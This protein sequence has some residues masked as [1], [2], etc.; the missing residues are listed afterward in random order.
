MSMLGAALAYF[1]AGI[2]IIPIKLDGSKSPALN[3]WRQL[4]EQP[5]S[6][7][8][9]TH[10]FRDRDVGLAVLAGKTSGG[11]T[12]IDFD[13]TG[14]FE[15]WRDLLDGLAPGLLERLP[16]VQT[17]G[18]HHVYL[19]ATVC[20]RN[21]KLAMAAE[22]YRK[23]WEDKDKPAIHDVVIETRGQGGYVVAPP[24]PP[25]AH[26][27]GIAY[28]HMSGPALTEIP[29]ITESEYE[30]L[31]N[32]ARAF[33]EQAKPA[34]E[35]RQTTKPSKPGEGAKPGEDFDARASWHE[36]LE[37][38]GWEAIRT[39]GDKTYWR[40]PGKK[41]G[42]ISA[43]TGH[44]GTKL[45]VFSSSAAPFEAERA[46]NKFSAY[47][48]LNCG[49]DYATAAREL[50]AKGFGEQRQPTRRHVPSEPTP[51]KWSELN[52]G[53]ERINGEPPQDFAPPPIG[54]DDV[55]MEY[56]EDKA[57]PERITSIVLEAMLDDDPAAVMRDGVFERVL[58][59][60]E[61]RAEW[62]L[63]GDVLRRKKKKADFNAA[64]KKHDAL[65][66]REVHK[67]GW[68]ASLLYRENKDGELVLENCLSNLITVLTHD[69]AWTNCLAFDDF[70]NQI[71]TRKPPPFVRRS[72]QWADEDALEIKSWV[73]QNYALRPNFAV[74]C[75]AIL[76]V[77]KRATF[78]SLRDYVEALED[79]GGEPAI[80]TWLVD[81]FGA[82]DSRYVREVG[83]KWLISAIAR[84]YEPGC[85][86]DTVLILEGKQGLKKSRALKQLCPMPAWFTDGL[87]ELGSKAQAEEIEGKWI[88]ELGELK[89]IGRDLDQTKAFVTR[90]AENYR[91]AYARYS[92]HRP[93][94]CVFAGTVNPG[95]AGY[96]RDETGNR[97]WW[98]V[99]CT[100][101]S[102]E[103]TPALRDQLWAE[104]RTLYLAGEK[105]W[106]ED[107]EILSAA[108]EEQEARA[109]M[110][111]WQE[112]IESHLI[113]K[114]E[115]ATDDILSDC[116]KI[117]KAKWDNASAQRVGRIMMSLKWPRFRRRTDDGRQ[118]WRY[119]N[120]NY[121]PSTTPPAP[122]GHDQNTMPWA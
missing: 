50:R 52:A 100:K 48:L 71:V 63:I 104:A 34:K 19:R 109:F 92:V 107:E 89:G 18:G 93:R 25:Q 24:S 98:P 32:A 11:L 6:E 54:D 45:W 3:K 47:G 88:V 51:D 20:D 75:E 70:S 26:V 85:K 37:P 96:L 43:T 99:L 38:H 62:L 102:P 117:E 69:D 110:D 58:A 39:I 68:K 35:E 17:P 86:V 90:E 103:I 61:D 80:D 1:K 74:T 28:L 56:R 8:A 41:D 87:S 31:L 84:A 105:W 7:A 76:V 29:T 12:I 16:V 120:P 49:G 14:A 77:A 119:Q 21:T 108:A 65:A 30:T 82:P 72:K 42:G 60:R 121:H 57:R 22:K 83:R 111:P 95:N 114:P 53:L 23:P 73:E 55:P 115:V 81:C 2:T 122:N 112:L 13:R 4:H 97:R 116:L 59:M 67:N 44:C 9:V 79:K 36:V 94:S 91:P 40:R 66:K 10:M 33:N 118:R 78:N 27:S 64:V 101:Q 113:G 15:A 5:P 46:Y 106:L